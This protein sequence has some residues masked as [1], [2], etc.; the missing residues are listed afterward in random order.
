MRL[1]P[2]ACA[3]LLLLVAGCVAEEPA[4]AP[5]D[6]NGTPVDGA[7]AGEAPVDDGSKPMATDLGHMPH[8]HDYWMGRER[9]T[10][11]DDEVQPSEDPFMILG[12]VPS[13]GAGGTFWQ[14]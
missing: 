1:V 12:S 14:L 9:V 8:M 2:V 5:V 13:G 10:L 11:F 4:D 3:A 7:A 6:A